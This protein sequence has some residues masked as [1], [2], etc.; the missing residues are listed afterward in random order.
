MDK[1]NQY[2]NLL[3]AKKAEKIVIAIFLVS[4]FLNDKENIKYSIR[5]EAVCLLKNTKTIAFEEIENHF[6]FYKKI[7]ENISNLISYFYI[8][9]EANLISKMNSEIIIEALRGL[10]NIF[11]KKQFQFSENNLSILEEEFFNEFNKTKLSNSNINSKTSFDILSDRNIKAQNMFFEKEI[12]N[13]KTENVNEIINDKIN[14]KRQNNKNLITEYGN[15]EIEQKEIETPINETKIISKQIKPNKTKQ[16]EEKKNNRREDILNL[17]TKGVEVSI[18]DISKKII[19]VSIKTLQRELNTLLEE[20]QI[21]KIGEKRWSK[22]ILN[23][24]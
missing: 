12:K 15:I 17:F 6:V 8:T 22:Y 5:D 1:E 19:G 4:Q 14:N 21:K 11:Y 23:Q 13:K 2:Q 10:E 7:L 18:N 24:N 9:K 3:L 16:N 20:G